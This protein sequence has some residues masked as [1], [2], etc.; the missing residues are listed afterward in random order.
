MVREHGHKSYELSKS[1]CLLYTS[2]L[3]SDEGFTSEMPVSDSP[4][5]FCSIHTDTVF[6]VSFTVTIIFFPCVYI[7]LRGIYKTTL[8]KNVSNLGFLLHL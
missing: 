3:H 2:S 1:K 7:K 8:M 5:S 4:F 6:L